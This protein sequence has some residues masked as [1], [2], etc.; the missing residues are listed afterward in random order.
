MVQTCLIPISFYSKKCVTVQALSKTYDI[1]KRFLCLRM[2]SK[3]QMLQKP[4]TIY[5]YYTT[6]CRIQQ[7]D[8]ALYLVG[9]ESFGVPQA[10]KPFKILNADHNQ[11]QIN[12]LNHA[13]IEKRL[14]WVIRHV[15]TI[16]QYTSSQQTRA[17]QNAIKNC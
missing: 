17:V 10:T 16:L 3:T 13:L 14:E 1:S 6:A 12:N 7:D 4:Q 5:S 9:P 2:Y 15:K 8:N 11:Q